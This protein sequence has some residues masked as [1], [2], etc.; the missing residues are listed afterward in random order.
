MDFPSYDV[1]CISTRKSEQAVKP[2]ANDNIAI[3]NILFI[4]SKN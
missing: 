1:L 4:A 3:V 2:T